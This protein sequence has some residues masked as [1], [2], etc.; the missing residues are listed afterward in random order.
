MAT[1]IDPY[2]DTP[3]LTPFQVAEWLRTLPQ[4]KIKGE[5][6]KAAARLV[7]ENHVDGD[8]FQ[9]IISEGRW[10]ELSIDDER[11]AVV[12]SRFF[13]QR[14]QEATMAEAARRS[15]A[16]NSSRRHM[17]GEMVVA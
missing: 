7:L 16:E 2:H 5:T 8:G 6:K 12:L 15:A 9:A 17:K 10:K 3:V 4:N 11:E 1:W 14:Q 13:Y